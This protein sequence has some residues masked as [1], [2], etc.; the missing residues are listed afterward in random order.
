MPSVS[1]PGTAVPIAA[2]H[3]LPARVIFCPDATQTGV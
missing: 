2:G 1:G 3:C